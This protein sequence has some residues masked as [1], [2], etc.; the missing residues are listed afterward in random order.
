MVGQVDQRRSQHPAAEQ[1]GAEKGRRYGQGVGHPHQQQ[2]DRDVRAP[3]DGAP[4]RAD[5][6]PGKGHHRPESADSEAAR[7]REAVARRKARLAEL[8]KIKAC[9]LDSAHCE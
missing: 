8:E 3:G 7:H 6:L 1:V 4:H 9:G 5:H 2:R